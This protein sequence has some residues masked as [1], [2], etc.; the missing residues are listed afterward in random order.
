MCV[1]VSNR[2]L[3]VLSIYDIKE[4]LVQKYWQLI[5]STKQLWSVP[6]IVSSMSRTVQ[7]WVPRCP[8]QYRVPR[9]PSQYRNVQDRSLRSWFLYWFLFSL[10]WPLLQIPVSRVFLMINWFIF[11]CLLVD[12]TVLDPCCWLWSP[13]VMPALYGQYRILFHPCPELSSTEYQDVQVS[14]E[15]RDVQVSTEMSRYR[16]V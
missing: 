14:T 5:L 8:G 12:K 2:K 11:F 1:R 7:Y 10:F 15:Y 6:N 13:D 16:D 4:L 3:T 9:C